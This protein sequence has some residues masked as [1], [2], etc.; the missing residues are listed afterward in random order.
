M[1]SYIGVDI[2]NSSLRISILDIQHDQLGPSQSLY[3]SS[4]KRPAD[5]AWWAEIGQF[6]AKHSSSLTNSSTIWL[7]SSVRRDATEVLLSQLKAM[8]GHIGHVI[9]AADLPLKNGVQIPGRVG[10]DRLLAALAASQS[11]EERPLIVVQA[12][13]AVTVDLLGGGDA[14]DI[15]VFQGGAILPGIPLM[16]KMLGAGTDLLPTELSADELTELPPLPGRSTQAAMLAGVASSLV[17]GVEHLVNRYRSSCGMTVPVILSGGD[18]FRLA[19]H[20]EAPVRVVAHLV[21]LGLLH[22]AKLHHSGR[23]QIGAGRSGAES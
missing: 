2:G 19:P 13:T 6:V 7:V 20:I 10:V 12:G 14:R 17:G 11:A 5:S 15:D 23:L 4:S 18:G 21:Q 1:C 22:L 9:Q 8:R 16:L 3:W